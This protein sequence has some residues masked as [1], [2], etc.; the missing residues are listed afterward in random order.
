MNTTI[1]NLQCLL[2]CITNSLN[3]SFQRLSNTEIDTLS[4]HLNQSLSILQ[5][6]QNQKIELD[7]YIELDDL[8]M[9]DYIQ[10]LSITSS[11]QSENSDMNNL[12]PVYVGIEFEDKN[13]NESEKINIV[14]DLEWSIDDSSNDSLEI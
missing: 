10:T 8:N 4:L 3:H 2:S 12:S 1:Q 13:V 11:I 7:E 14:S 5:K 9:L 6:K